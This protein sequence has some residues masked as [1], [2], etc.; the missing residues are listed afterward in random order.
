MNNKPIFAVRMKQA[1][2]EKGMTQAELSR[3]TAIHKATI[4]QYLCGRYKA[5]QD[6]V[7]KIASVLGCDPMWLLGYTDDKGSNVPE[8]GPYQDLSQMLSVLGG[9]L[10]NNGSLS[11]NDIQGYE[12]AAQEY[13]NKAYFY[14]RIKDNNMSPVIETGDLLLCRMC[15][16]LNNGD[17][18][19]FI[20]DRISV[21]IGKYTEEADTIILNS[22]NPLWQPREFAAEQKNRIII[23]AKVISFTHKYE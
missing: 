22:I 21:F 4:N 8:N 12:I 18:G 14:F 17:V 10:D 20:I 3:R 16:Q 19:L 5:K 2:E 11:Y 6:G 13:R 15:R 9:A 1:L 7:Y 23:E